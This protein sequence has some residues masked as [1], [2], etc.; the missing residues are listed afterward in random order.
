[1]K[2]NRTFDLPWRGGKNFNLFEFNEKIWLEYYINPHKIC[3]FNVKTA[4]CIHPK[5]TH[6]KTMNVHPKRSR[7]SEMRG[8]ACCVKLFFEGNII[9]F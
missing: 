2:N 5:E 7:R 3:E 9:F 1:M 6:A 8:N 4:Q